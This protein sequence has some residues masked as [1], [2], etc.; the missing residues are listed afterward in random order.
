MQ[1]AKTKRE[2]NSKKHQK[3]LMVMYGI[4]YE[5]ALDWN[6]IQN[7][8]EERTLFFVFGMVVYGFIIQTYFLINGICH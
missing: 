8:N 1:F 6:L 2:L 5:E 7:K 3:V 4:D